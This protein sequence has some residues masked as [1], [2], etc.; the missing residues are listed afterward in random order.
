M[1]DSKSMFVRLA[2]AASPGSLLEMQILR[3]YFRPTESETLGVRCPQSLLAVC[4][5]T[6]ST[7]DSNDAKVWELLM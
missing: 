1:S 3:S 6:G 2:A 7:P 4:F 5:F